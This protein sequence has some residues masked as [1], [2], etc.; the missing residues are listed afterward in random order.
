[1]LF[2]GIFGVYYTGAVANKASIDYMNS[3]DLL[4]ENDKGCI[5]Y[6]SVVRFLKWC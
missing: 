6:D 2:G 5:L 4:T 3:L 1:M